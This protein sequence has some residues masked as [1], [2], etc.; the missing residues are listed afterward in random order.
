MTNLEMLWF[1]PSAE[2][3]VFRAPAAWKYGDERN[4]LLSES[5]KVALFPLLKRAQNASL[6]LLCLIPVLFLVAFVTI[7][8]QMPG[9]EATLKG[10][11]PIAL[12]FMVMAIVGLLLFL[13]VC[14]L[15]SRS[16]IYGF[17]LGRSAKAILEGA[18]RT[19]DAFRASDA[20]KQQKRQSPLFWI[21]LAVIAVL[22]FAV[23]LYV[24][25][26]TENAMQHALTV[27]SGFSALCVTVSAIVIVLKSRR[28]SE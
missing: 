25:L 8:S 4:Y 1:K 10:S 14:V 23:Q 12:L 15:A 7:F 16:L 9:L 22:G 20:V 28:V 27:I 3:W 2:K 13:F 6:S 26:T 21:S 24:A 11:F 18:S 17:W 19:S 5:Q